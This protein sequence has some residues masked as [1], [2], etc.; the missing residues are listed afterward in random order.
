ML[1]LFTYI[2]IR[3]FSKKKTQEATCRCITSPLSLVIRSLLQLFVGFFFWFFSKCNCW[4]WPNN[5]S[6]GF[7]L[8]GFCCRPKMFEKITVK[9]RWLDKVNYL[10][11]HIG[12]I[13]L[14]IWNILSFKRVYFVLSRRVDWECDIFLFRK[15][16]R[17]TKVNLINRVSKNWTTIKVF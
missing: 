17:C 7:C 16:K 10:K 3:D 5:F 14:F 8:N 4:S 9:T 11:I 6:S 1:E 13:N 2:Q 15:T 12:G